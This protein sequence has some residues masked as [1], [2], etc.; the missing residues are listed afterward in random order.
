MNSQIVHT[1]AARQRAT[2][3]TNLLLLAGILVVINI[4]GVS[5]F[6]RWDMTGKKIYSLSRASKEAVRSLG[7]RLTI[8]GYFSEDLPAQYASTA[9]YV[10]DK[11]DDYKAF[12][13]NRVHFEFVDPASEEQLQEEALSYGIQPVQMQAIERDRVELKLVYMALVFLYQDRVETIPVVE[14]TAGLEYDLTTAIRAV[15]RESKP[16]V[17][18][19]AGHG[20]AVPEQNAEGTGVSIWRQELE[21]H[22]EVRTVHVDSFRTV[23]PDV[24]AL[25]IV[26]PREGFSAWERYAIDQFIMRGGRTGW[27]IDAVDAD[28][29]QSQQGMAPPMPLGM[30]NWLAHYGVRVRT[31][32]VMDRYNQSIQMQSQRGIFTVRELVPYPFFPKVENYNREHPLSKEL[33]EMTFLYASPIDTSLARPDSTAGSDWI[34]ITPDT[35]NTWPARPPRV[36]IE[37]II[38][39]SSHS[40]MQEEFF[41]IQPNQAMAEGNFRGGPYPIAA[42]VTGELESAFATAPA[43]PDSIT[44]PAHLAGPVENRL[45]VV[46]DATFARDRYQQM[47]QGQNLTFLLNTVDWLLQDEGLIGI[48][49]KEID[50]RP[51]RELGNAPRALLK[52]LNI[53]LPSLLAIGAGVMWWRYRRRPVRQRL[54]TLAAREG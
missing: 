3:R 12:G 16:V 37:P 24:E 25:F 34:Q 52:W 35:I 31:A 27:L 38:Y 36:V 49:A 23:P 42:T 22:Y 1:T 26:G 17:A 29:Q 32:L 8:K 18:F 40:S 11:L 19:L 28:L 7:D 54:E 33:P 6:A 4:L 46:G 47:L 51:L 9:R 21:S 39:T 30:E 5:L 2:R 15:S 48:R 50:Y 13:R 53:L 20:M 43:V 41:F 44:L 45:V 10:R 14:S